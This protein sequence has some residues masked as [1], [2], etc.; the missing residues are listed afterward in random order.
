VAGG[1]RRSVDVE[2]GPVDHPERGV[3]AEPFLGELRR[4]PGRQGRQHLRRERLVDLVV[5]E[6]L[7][8]QAAAGQHPGHR[9]RRGHQQALVAVHEVD[10]GGL[11]VGEV[12]QHRQRV[13]PRPFLGCQQHGGRAIGEGRRVAGGHRGVARFRA[14]G[15]EDRLELGEPVQAG[16]GAQVLVAGQPQIGRDQVVEEAPVVRG[17][18]ALVRGQRQGV[19]RL[20]V[21]LPA[22]GGDRGVLAHRQAGARLGV[23]GNLRAERLLGAELGGGLE[24][25]AQGAGPVELQQRPP[26][27]LVELQRRVRGGVHP[28]GDADLQ[29]TQRD[30]VGDR[31]DGFQ[32]GAAGLLDVVRRGAGVQARAEDDLPGEVE[33]ARVLEHRAGDHLADPLPGQPVPGDQ[34]VQGGGQH[35]LVAGVGIAAAGPGE[36]DPVAAEDGDTA[37]GLHGSPPGVVSNLLAS[38]LLAWVTDTRASQIP[39]LAGPSCGGWVCPI[40]PGCGVMTRVGR[41]RPD[42]CCWARLP[43]GGW[44]ARSANCSAGPAST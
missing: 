26:H 13:C 21:D 18:E 1:Q 42:R 28:G 14:A 17:G 41:S 30:L 12:G 35:V 6:I 36:R 29:L 15:A 25:G 34:P 43:A 32:P 5:V 22:P 2:P 10:R 19:L 24:A 11:A 31:D 20:A 44:P 40:R 8:G 3:Q 16:V 33:V 23:A 38:R 9:V 27:V 37:R 4:L 7:Q 39:I